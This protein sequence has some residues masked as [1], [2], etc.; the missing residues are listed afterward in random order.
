MLGFLGSS[1]PDGST[2]NLP[3]QKKKRQK[4]KILRLYAINTHVR[5][6]GEVGE[7][8]YVHLEANNI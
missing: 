6:H 7:N 4:Q 3:T 1:H 2:L 5:L 8:V